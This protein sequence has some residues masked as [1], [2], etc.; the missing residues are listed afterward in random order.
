M[1]WPGGG[2][3]QHAEGDG[4]RLAQLGRFDAG[5]GQH[6]QAVAFGGEEAGQGAH[7]L[8]ARNSLRVPPEGR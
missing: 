2:R 5:P 3:V 4:R 7:V 1:G 8:R 6:G